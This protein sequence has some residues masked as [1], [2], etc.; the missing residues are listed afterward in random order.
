MSISLTPE[1]MEQALVTC[2]GARQS[3]AQGAGQSGATRKKKRVLNYLWVDSTVNASLNVWEDTGLIWSRWARTKSSWL[4]IL[5]TGLCGKD[6]RRTR[7]R[8][9]ARQQV[10]L[11]SGGDTANCVLSEGVLFSWF[12]LGIA[13]RLGGDYLPY[14]MLA[15]YNEMGETTKDSCV[16]CNWGHF[17]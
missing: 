1:F 4:E 12:C 13:V 3:G 17:S 9:W 5:T 11:L 7:I 6:V 15:Y 14:V 10:F 2:E 16:H 8:S